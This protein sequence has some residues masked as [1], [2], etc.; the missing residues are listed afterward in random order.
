MEMRQSELR[1]I[2][3][4][5]WYINRNK[6]PLRAA[7]VAL[8]LCCALSR[9][10]PAKGEFRAGGPPTDFDGDDGWQFPTVGPAVESIARRGVKNIYKQSEF[11]NEIRNLI[12]D[13]CSK[14]NGN[15]VWNGGDRLMNP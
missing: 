13:K 14:I 11:G 7:S 2:P 5:D 6:R 4:Y 15:N 10:L 1:A 9:S 12:G 8:I 3:S